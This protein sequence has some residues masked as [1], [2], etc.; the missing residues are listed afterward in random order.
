MNQ[1]RRTAALHWRT[2]RR[3]NRD[4]VR[5]S[6]KRPR[7]RAAAAAFSELGMGNLYRS[8]SEGIWSMRSWI[9]VF[10]SFGVLGERSSRNRTVSRRRTTDLGE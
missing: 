10:E 7:V 5:Y 8:I 6:E 2:R 1:Y 4:G 3:G 9:V